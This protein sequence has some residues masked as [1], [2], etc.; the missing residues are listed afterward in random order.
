MIYALTPTDDN[1]YAPL[2]ITAGH[3]SLAFFAKN[4]GVDRHFCRDCG[5]HV[6]NY[7]VR[8]NK[9]G[10][11]PGTWRGS[12]L[13]VEPTQHVNYESAMVKMKDGRDKYTE[14]SWNSEKCDQ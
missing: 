12:G 9:L 7:V 11:F 1:K 5:S 8:A 2:V 14:F 10:L 4:A 13:D 3:D 6:F